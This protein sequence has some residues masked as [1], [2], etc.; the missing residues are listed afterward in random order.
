MA[1]RA[2]NC[3]EAGWCVI[4]YDRRPP[5]H[6][7]PG[8]GDRR[9]GRGLQGGREPAS[10]SIPERSGV[11]Y[12]YGEERWSWTL[13]GT[14][15]TDYTI[16]GAQRSGTASRGKKWTVTLSCTQWGQGT[17]TPSSAVGSARTPSYQILPIR[18]VLA[19]T[20]TLGTT[21]SW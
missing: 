20:R 3:H 9:A 15:T 21:R 19:G 11:G 1:R 2:T 17:M 7:E 4:L 14:F 13:E 10:R 5:G 12:P 16:P 6:D 8:A 18:K